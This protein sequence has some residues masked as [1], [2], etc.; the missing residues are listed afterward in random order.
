MSSYHTSNTSR[1]LLTAGTFG[2]IQ[3]VAASDR[4]MIET[5]ARNYDALG[6]LHREHA[7]ANLPLDAAIRFRDLLSEAINH[8]C[9]A[10]L[11]GRQTALWSDT[12]VKAEAQ[13]FG[14][15]RTA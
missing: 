14:R 7:L 15:R 2:E 1:L 12:T 10:T 3:L 8:A 4:V 5:S 11:D 9:S 6:H 13:R